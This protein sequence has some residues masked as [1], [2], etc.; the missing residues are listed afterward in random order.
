MEVTWHM[1]AREDKYYREMVAMGKALGDL[2]SLIRVKRQNKV[3]EAKLSYEEL[4][5]LLDNMVNE[6]YHAQI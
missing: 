6:R 5:N 2:R 4:D 3:S 1:D